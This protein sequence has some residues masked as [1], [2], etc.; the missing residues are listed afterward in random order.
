MAAMGRKMHL[1]VRP[2]NEREIPEQVED[3][4]LARTFLE[5]AYNIN[6]DVDPFGWDQPP[7]LH[8]LRMRAR[9]AADEVVAVVVDSTPIPGFHL[10]VSDA[11]AQGARMH[12]VL[13]HVAE[14]WRALMNQ[15]PFRGMDV[16]A[17]QGAV[18]ISEGWMLT[19]TQDEDRQRAAEERRIHEHPDRVEVRMITV[20]GPSGLRVMLNYPR[21]GVPQHLIGQ[22]RP[23]QV[24][25]SYQV[26]GD[27]P[28]AL[29]YLLEV[30][31]GHEPGAW[32]SFREQFPDE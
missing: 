13:V 31:Q 10:L 1:V 18:L 20:A 16:S 23:G 22:A 8:V 28:D 14:S 12:H 11:M 4:V 2:L 9:H 21:D 26:A 24:P 6:T 17:V 25:S 30:M 27:L 5:L 19:G 3:K 15:P 32:Q 7:S 29:Q